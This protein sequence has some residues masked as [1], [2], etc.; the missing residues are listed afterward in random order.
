MT[1]GIHDTHFIAARNWLCLFNMHSTLTVASEQARSLLA[2]I[3]RGFQH[4]LQCVELA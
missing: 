3:L 2:P 4:L 1:N